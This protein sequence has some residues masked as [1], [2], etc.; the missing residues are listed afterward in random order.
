MKKN[1]V[2]TRD[3]AINLTESS[4]VLHEYFNIEPNT[5]EM[6]VFPVKPGVCLCLPVM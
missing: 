4:T 1:T 5:L 6:W 3:T 2:Q